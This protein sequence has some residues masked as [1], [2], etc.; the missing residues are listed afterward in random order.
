MPQSGIGLLASTAL[1]PQMKRQIK[2]KKFDSDVVNVLII[3]VTKVWNTGETGDIYT[4]S[5]LKTILFHI[6]YVSK[7]SI[8]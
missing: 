1:V 8:L 7:I 3:T 4:S 5:L 2:I 6:D